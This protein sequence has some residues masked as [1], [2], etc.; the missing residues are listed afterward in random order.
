MLGPRLNKTVFN[1]PIPTLTEDEA[2]ALAVVQ[3][4][5]TTSRDSRFPAQ[6]QAPHCWGK[7]N[8]WL[9][10][11]KSTKGDEDGCKHMRQR[12]LS[13]CPSIWSEKWDEEREEGTF[14]GIKV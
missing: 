8:E 3:S 10:C 6:N 11:I 5:R 1:T 9:L 4:V 12:A 14:A 13:I 7:Y 2:A